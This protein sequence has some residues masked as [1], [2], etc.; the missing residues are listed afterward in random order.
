MKGP[1][2]KY[3]IDGQVFNMLVG[4]RAEVGHGTAYKTTGGLLAKDLVLI[5][6]RWKSKK[7]HQTA[8]AEK[9]LEKHGYFAKKGKFGYVKKTPKSSPKKSRSKSKK[10]PHT[11][12]GKKTR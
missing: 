3:H 1:D 5:K 12:G 8:K 11:I 6:G 2:G 4:S 7:K 9:R 10:R